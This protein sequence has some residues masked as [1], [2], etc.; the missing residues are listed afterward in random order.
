MPLFINH[1]NADLRHVVKFLKPCL[2]RRRTQ[3]IRTVACVYLMNSGTGFTTQ[4]ARFVVYI[5]VKDSGGLITLRF[6]THISA[7]E[8]KPCRWLVCT[9]D[10]P[11][12]LPLLIVPVGRGIG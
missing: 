8:Q 3:G 6:S 2:V 9:A 1:F 10:N 12:T 11:H 5:P 7:I 4:G